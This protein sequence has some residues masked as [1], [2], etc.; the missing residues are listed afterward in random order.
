MQIPTQILQKGNKIVWMPQLSCMTLQQ[1]LV[2]S[3]KDKESQITGE[4]VGL[5]RLRHFPSHDCKCEETQC[6][7][8][9]GNNLLNQRL[10]ASFNQQM[11]AKQI[12]TKFL[13]WTGFYYS[14]YNF[15]PGNSYPEGD[16]QSIHPWFIQVCL[17]RCFLSCFFICL[18]RDF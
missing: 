7:C 6:H 1:W 17:S 3:Q 4:A 2:M 10:P 16:F 9:L 18:H 15:L 13:R 5:R 11:I 14:R 12:F 8:A